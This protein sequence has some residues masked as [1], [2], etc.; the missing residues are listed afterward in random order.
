MKNK[1]VAGLLALFFGVFGIHKF[2]LNETK[3]GIIYLSCYLIGLLTCLLIVG[4]I[5]MIVISILALIDAIKL[6]VMDDQF[7]D[8]K[9]N[10]DFINRNNKEKIVLND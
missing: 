6:L 7:F 2:Y 5:P 10:Q 3:S 9:Y 4:L 1:I 8:E